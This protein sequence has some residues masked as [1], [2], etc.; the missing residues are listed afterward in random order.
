[1]KEFTSNNQQKICEK[2]AQLN[3]KKILGEQQFNQYQ[4][5]LYIYK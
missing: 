2:I 3:T 1:M 4:L 5:K